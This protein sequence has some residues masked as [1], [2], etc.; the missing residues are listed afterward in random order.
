[1]ST[2]LGDYVTITDTI[3]NIKSMPSKALPKFQL[4]PWHCTNTHVIYS[5]RH[6][7]KNRQVSLN[8]ERKLFSDISIA[9]F[10]HY[11]HSILG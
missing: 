10:A 5:K 4:S 8:K 3:T 2:K 9:I 1:M 6:I 7:C 11:S